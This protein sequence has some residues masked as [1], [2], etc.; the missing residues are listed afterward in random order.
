MNKKFICASHERCTFE[1]YVP[2]PY[3][4]KAFE[5]E[6]N[7]EYAEI[8][9]CGLGFYVLYVNGK[10]I[11][12]GA[13]AP[14]ISNPD[15]L[16]YYDTYNITK[17]LSKGKNVIGIVLG[18]G[19][20]NPF[21][22]AVWD[23][24]KAEWINAPCVALEFKVGEEIV[25]EAD[26][27]FKTC[28][29]PIVFDELRMGEHYDANKEIPGW[30]TVEFDDT[31]WENA[32]IAPTPRGKLTP[33]TVEPVQ[34]T[35]EIL[36][37]NIFKQDDSF[38]YDFGENNAGVC[39]LKIKAEK[40]QRIEYWHGEVLTDGKFDN[41]STIFDRPDAPFYKEY[42]QKEVY[43][44]KGEGI[45]EYTPSFT[46]HGFRYVL[47]KGITEEQATK[48]L[49]TYKVMNSDLK[50]I[51]G[52]TCSDET[53][54]TLFEM[55]KRSDRSN[56]FYFPT[57]CPH[58]EKNGWTGDI[59]M[60]I[61]HMILLYD[62]EKS[63]R[64]WL[65]GLRAAQ[66]DS[67]QIPV[68][69]PTYDWGYGWG[70]GPAWDSVLFNVPYQLYKIRGCKDVVKENAHAMIA[71]LDYILKKRKSD[72]TVSYGLG[73]WCPVGKAEH[74]YNVPL[75]VT[76]T[77]M[78]M[79]MAGKASEMLE[80]IGYTHQATFAKNIYNDFRNTIREKLLD[81][82]TMMIKGNT[83]SGQAMAL[84]YGVFEKEEEQQAFAGLMKCIKLN[85]NNF[86]SGF[87]GLHVLFHILTRF[88]QSELAY[89]MITKREFPSYAYLIDQGETTLIEMLRNDGY[90]RGSHNHHF[91]GD[92]ARWFIAAIAGINV[93]DSKT[94]IVKPC[95]IERLEHASA[96]YE[97]PAGRVSVSWRR[98]DRDIL[99]EVICHDSLNCNIILPEGYDENNVRIVTAGIW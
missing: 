98:T 12:K 10:N 88:G 37:V 5:L 40:G 56:Y 64:E 67:G 19:F 59:S 82:D 33:C 72:G 61:D 83:Q 85:H 30:N 80:A 62:V 57:D 39:T 35:K 86:D 95:F 38:V 79:D 78:V 9:I 68:I 31:A 84:Y 46:Y 6:K 28:P 69:V 41:Y 77:I 15:H 92:I 27:S 58:R 71:Y 90:R 70:T 63:L 43:I 1:K 49:L 96:Y 29:S 53:V 76:D 18:N 51:G 4:R 23:F 3:F 36:P 73:D 17:Y 26:E 22:G 87:L 65:N 11:T 91:F 94:V 55:V 54:N 13:L 24:D 99:L 32:M 81:K 75:E 97:L 7:P 50:E 60:S 93:I 14:Y 89:Y 42:S 47:V 20:F 48:E 45:E 34:I 2:A 16:C 8:S 44:C 21:A 74:Q 66:N 52:F 25:F